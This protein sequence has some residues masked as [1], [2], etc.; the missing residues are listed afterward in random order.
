MDIK[1]KIPQM[2]SE[3]EKEDVTKQSSSSNEI[4]KRMLIMKCLIILMIRNDFDI[5][6][7]HSQ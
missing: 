4:E 6:K 3:K 1:E 2:T 7:F 5:Y